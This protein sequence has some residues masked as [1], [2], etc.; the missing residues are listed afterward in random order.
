MPRAYCNQIVTLIN[1]CM[2]LFFLALMSTEGQLC[3]TFN[4]LA[5]AN[6]LAR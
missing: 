5:Y 3:E 2:I 4:N 1:E 6:A